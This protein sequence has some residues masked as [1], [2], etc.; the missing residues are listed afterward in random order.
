M[1]SILTNFGCHWSCPYCV[2]RENKIDIPKTTKCSFDFNKLETQIG[3]SN[4]DEVSIS[5]GGDPLH[6]WKD[7]EWFFRNII[8]SCKRNNKKLELHTS[9]I[10]YDFDYSKFNR[11][12]FHLITPTQINIINHNKLKLPSSV[13]AVFVVQ[14]HFTKSLLLKI[15]N[16]VKNNADITEL[17]FRQRITSSGEC[18]Y[19]EH[20]FLKRFHLDKWYYIEQDDYNEY[21]VNDRIEKRYLDI[22]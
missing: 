7:N 13:R 22:R 8:N 21:F 11:V 16:E 6:N 4:E 1:L 9:Y 5:G 10:D 20:K 17:S 12:V 19:K 15:S 18:D 14:E 2:Y 3:L